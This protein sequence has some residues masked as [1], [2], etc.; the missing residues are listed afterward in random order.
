MK[1]KEELQIQS[2]SDYA[3]DEDILKYKYFFQMFQKELSDLYKERRE[4]QSDTTIT[5]KEKN[6]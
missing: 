2:N 1:K 5:Q 6:I 4:V 3:T